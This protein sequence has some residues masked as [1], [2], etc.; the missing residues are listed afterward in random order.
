MADFLTLDRCYGA[1]SV[2]KAILVIY[3]ILGF[4]PQTIQG[5]DILAAS[6][7]NR[8]LCQASLKVSRLISL[9]IF[10]ESASGCDT[11]CAKVSTSNG[12]VETALCSWFPSRVPATGVAKTPKVLAEAES[13]SG[14]KAWASHGV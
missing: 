14:K 3:D 11:E 6:G 13:T 12:R 7:N 8:S 10:A 4:F 5:A 1:A 9:R 2:K